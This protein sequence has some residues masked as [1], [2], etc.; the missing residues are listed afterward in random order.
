MLETVDW[1]ESLVGGWKAWYGE[2]CGGKLCVSYM[3]MFI[4][5]S[6]ILL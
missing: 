5:A 6:E 1:I 4:I 3:L 2:L